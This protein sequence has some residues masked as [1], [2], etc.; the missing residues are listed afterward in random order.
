MFLH[1]MSVH[2]SYMA[3]GHAVEMRTVVEPVPEAVEA[4][5]YQVFRRSEVEPRINCIA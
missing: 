1:S 4:I 2:C 5:L 3:L